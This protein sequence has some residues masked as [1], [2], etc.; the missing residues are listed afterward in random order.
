LKQSKKGIR[1]NQ[2]VHI[3]LEYT[4]Q[5]WEWIRVR[6]HL[7]ALPAPFYP[8]QAAELVG[9]CGRSAALRRV[10]PY[11]SLGRL[12]LGLP[13]SSRERGSLSSDE[14]PCLYFYQGQYVV[15]SYDN[16]TKWSFDTAAQAVAF[17]Q[18]HLTIIP[19]R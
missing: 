19:R 17:A 15:A 18:Q 5:H 10:W 8:Q 1:T 9:H 11:V 16:S 14:S 7:L 2:P 4:P 13:G 12:G 3:R 6:K